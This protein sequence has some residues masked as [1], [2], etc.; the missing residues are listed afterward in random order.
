MDLKVDYDLLDSIGATMRGLMSEVNG[1]SANVDQYTDAYGSGPVAGAMGGFA[2]NWGKHKSELVSNMQNLH[3]MVGK[4]K[5][6]FQESD[7]KLKN[8]LTS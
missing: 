1:M 7:E 8:E 6:T 4:S 3:D 2:D 5:T